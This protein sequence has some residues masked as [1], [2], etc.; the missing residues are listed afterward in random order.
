M[1][2]PRIPALTVDERTQ[3]ASSLGFIADI[4]SEWTDSLLGWI[5]GLRIGLGYHGL[6][7]QQDW[8]LERL[9]TLAA[10]K[11]AYETC[12]TTIATE[13]SRL[14]SSP[15]AWASS[16]QSIGGGPYHEGDALHFVAENLAH[17]FVDSPGDITLGLYAISLLYQKDRIVR[18]LYLD[19]TNTLHETIGPR[20][21]TRSDRIFGPWMTCDLDSVIDSAGIF[22]F[23]ERSAAISNEADMAALRAL[24]AFHLWQ[25]CQV[26][27]TTKRP[28]ATLRHKLQYIKD[29][30]DSGQYEDMLPDNIDAIVNR[31]QRSSPQAEVPLIPWKH[32]NIPENIHFPPEDHGWT[33]PSTKISLMYMRHAQAIYDEISKSAA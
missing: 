32:V 11:Q 7:E 13:I 9:N 27:K 28:S 23:S 5:D 12:W 16:L 25:I 26:A 17:T 33:S 30:A 19:F 10:L 24:S 22:R 20:M 18:S 1:T 2:S 6:S 29:L 15:S 3:V 31:I 8:A 4:E 21:P 14:T